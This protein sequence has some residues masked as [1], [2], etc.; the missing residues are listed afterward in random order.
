MWNS[1]DFYPWGA[2]P[3]PN[4]RSAREPLSSTRRV[5]VATRDRNNHAAA[6]LH[7]RNRKKEE[8]DL[9]AQEISLQNADPKRCICVTAGTWF[10][11]LFSL[12]IKTRGEITICVTLYI[13]IY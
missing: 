9:Y 10:E 2:D 12:E 7:Y 8:D 6:V 11:F 13:L 5:H 4:A 3:Q 1:V